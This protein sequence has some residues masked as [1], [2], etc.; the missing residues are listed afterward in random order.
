M[1][2]VICGG[3]TG[4]HVSPAIAIYEALKEE[5]PTASFTFIGRKNGRENKA[6]VETGEKLLTLNMHGINGSSP[7]KMASGIF[8]AGKALLDAGRIL[9][10]EG[11]S[12][13][14]GTGGYV[15]WP[16][17]TAAQIRGIPTFIHE[18]NAYPGLTTRLV[19]KRATGVMLNY[20]DAEKRIKSKENVS[21]V[22][23]PLRKDFKSVNRRIARKKLGIRDTELFILSFGG[24]LG[25]K[26]L[27]ETVIEFMKCYSTKNKNAKH[28]HATGH[29]YYASLS[30]KD[31]DALSVKNGCMIVPYVDTMAEAM[32]A[33][34]IVICRCGAMTL[35]EICAVGVASILIP[36]PNVSEN[37]Q[38]KNG[39]FMAEN[40]AAVLIE[41]NELNER[42]LLD[43]VRML[44][45]DSELR[46]SIS[47]KAKAL[48]CENASEKIK[49]VILRNIHF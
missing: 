2:F 13:V 34:D 30:Q 11:A 26:K 1:K 32:C 48:A 3:G 35:S 27:N 28:L 22:G 31:K 47:S 4:G 20:R 40:G 6:Y 21:V 12:A 36:S 37:H 5:L 16:V 7:V 42:R 23:N 44:E 45:N 29:S 8:S 38:L 43:A 9:K 46:Q 18:S 24:S 19:S 10:S 41:E 25:S 39:T 49:E 33:A 15:S 14:I 17:L